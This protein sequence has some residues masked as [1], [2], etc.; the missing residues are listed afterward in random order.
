[1]EIQAPRPQKK[2]LNENLE[3]VKR[4]DSPLMNEDQLRRIYRE[5]PQEIR[6]LMAT[7]GFFSPKVESSLEP[8]N[9]KWLARFVVDPGEPSRVGQV[10][11]EFEGAVKE[12]KKRISELRERWQLKAGEIFG[13]EQWESAKRALLRELSAKRYAYARIVGSEAKVHP[14]ERRVDLNVTY[15]S[16]PE[17]LFGEIHVSGLQRY[18]GDIVENLSP[19]KPGEPYDQEALL[20]YQTRLIDTGYFGSAFVSLARDPADPARAPVEVSLVEGSAKRLGFGIGFSTDTGARGQIDYSDHNVRDLGWRFDSN[21]TL[22]QKR[23]RA[24]ARFTLPPTEKGYR[25][26]FGTDFERTDVENQETLRLRFGGER[27]RKRGDYETAVGLQ[28]LIEQQRV[29]GSERDI[30]RALAPSYVWTA[31]KVNDLI[32]PERGY[33]LNAQ[34]AGASELVLSDQTFVRT[35]GKGAWFYPLADFGRLLVRGEIGVVWAESRDGIPTDFLFRTGGDQSV[36]GYEFQSLGVREGDAIVGGRYLAVGSV[37]YVHVLS[38][39][40]GAAIFYD[41]G[42]AADEWDELEPVSGYGIGARYRSP[43]GPINVDLAYGEDESEFRLH[44]SVGFSF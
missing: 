25:D 21:L 34:L 9:G 43:V 36:R 5:T 16:G 38:A 33:L 14:D 40:W 29:E 26:S 20:E 13:Q 42:N 44:L 8:A 3:I 27:A 35:Y 4:R 39:N 23:Q 10:T 22:E 19:I 12:E 2:L 31:R 11:I 6:K 24:N 41:Y 7:Q 30:N 18:S 28:Y 1:V 15:E 32:Y 37:E 17:V